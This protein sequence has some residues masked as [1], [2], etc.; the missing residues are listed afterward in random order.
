MRCAVGWELFS[1]VLLPLG[2]P[3]FGFPIFGF[4]LFGFPF[5]IKA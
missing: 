5:F 1:A 2:F 3:L 4:P